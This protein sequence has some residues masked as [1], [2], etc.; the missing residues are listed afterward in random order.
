MGRC[1][2]QAHRA[3]PRVGARIA[4]RKSHVTDTAAVSPVTEAPNCV[5][6]ERST[7]C[8]CAKIITDLKSSNRSLQLAPHRCHVS[9]SFQKLEK[10]H[11][12]DIIA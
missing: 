1:M 11:P 4:L 7:E 5:H 3:K 10:L 6:K 9:G 2:C 12:K 8:V